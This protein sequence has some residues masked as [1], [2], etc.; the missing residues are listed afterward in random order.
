MFHTHIRVHLPCCYA[1]ENY[2]NL[3]FIEE[4][5]DRLV[6]EKAKILLNTPLRNLRDQLTMKQSLIGRQILLSLPKTTIIKA[7]HLKQITSIVERHV[8]LYPAKI[9]ARMDFQTNGY[10]WLIHVTPPTFLK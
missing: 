6:Q 9:I 8:P 2:N 1:Y 10:R 7:V 3:L 5:L 4:R